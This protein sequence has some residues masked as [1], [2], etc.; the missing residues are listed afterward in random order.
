MGS[1]GKQKCN[2]S[3]SIFSLRHKPPLDYSRIP[4]PPFFV[5]YITLGFPL[6]FF[7]PYMFHFILF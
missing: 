3:G 1:Q 4:T 6:P 5:P 2:V 7:V